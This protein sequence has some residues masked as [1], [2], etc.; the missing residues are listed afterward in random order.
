MCRTLQNHLE[1]GSLILAARKQSRHTHNR[2]ST[3]YPTSLTKTPINPKKKILN[4]R[5]NG[6]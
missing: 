6:K 3:F 5:L 2:F 4:A 1:P